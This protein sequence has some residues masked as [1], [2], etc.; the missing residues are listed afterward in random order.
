MHIF[1]LSYCSKICNLLKV[2]DQAGGRYRL[3]SE[4]D[5]H[6]HWISELIWSY[7]QFRLYFYEELSLGFSCTH[8]PSILKLDTVP[9]AI[10]LV[11]LMSFER[12]CTGFHFSFFQREYFHCNQT[13]TTTKI[14]HHR[15]SKVWIMDSGDTL[16]NSSNMTDQQ[17]CKYKENTAFLIN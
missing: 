3:Q 5:K 16:E 4:V 14:T 6:L 8:V 10:E 13:T 7:K 2:S 17:H 1:T 11:M 12:K 15:F 9:S